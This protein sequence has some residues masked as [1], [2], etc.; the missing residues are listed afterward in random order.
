MRVRGDGES[1]IAQDLIRLLEVA[2]LS[3]D[4][5]SQQT[6]GESLEVLIEATLEVSVSASCT[7]CSDLSITRKF[8]LSAACNGG[9]SKFKQVQSTLTRAG[10]S[11]TCAGHS[12]ISC[13][14]VN[15]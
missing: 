2:D 12:D 13:E 7:W 8:D 9:Q 4:L 6:S 1:A 5:P 11:S 3:G 10:L 15:H 14:W